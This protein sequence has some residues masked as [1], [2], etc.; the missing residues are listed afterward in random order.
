MCCLVFAHK[1]G[2]FVVHCIFKLLCACAN[3]LVDLGIIEQQVEH[4]RNE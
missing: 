3:D 4:I 2:Y 1:L